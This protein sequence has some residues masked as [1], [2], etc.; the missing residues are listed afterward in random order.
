MFCLDSAP[1]FSFAV[2]ADHDQQSLYRFKPFPGVV[3]EC[4]FVTVAFLYKKAILES[5]R[6][7]RGLGM[8]SGGALKGIWGRSVP[9]RPSERIKSF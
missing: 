1:L 6:I 2:L 5:T 9:L 3:L 8:E 7:R 4:L